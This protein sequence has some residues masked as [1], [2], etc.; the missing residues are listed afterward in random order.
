MTMVRKMELLK[1]ILFIG[2]RNLGNIMAY[3]SLEWE[4]G[5]WNTGREFSKRL[6]KRIRMNVTSSHAIV[7]NSDGDEENVKAGKNNE[8]KVE[9]VSHLLGGQ[10]QDYE[11]IAKNTKTANTRLKTRNINLK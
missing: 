11:N 7:K 10:N 5:H 2:N 8:K 9:R 6:F 3:N 4:N 1:R